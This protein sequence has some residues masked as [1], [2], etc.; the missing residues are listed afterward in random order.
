MLRPRGASQLAT[1]A[2][3]PC[4][5]LVALVAALA[6]QNFS[7]LEEWLR[8][9]PVLQPRQPIAIREQPFGVVAL[10]ERRMPEHKRNGVNCQGR[11]TYSFHRQLASKD[12]SDL[13]LSKPSHLP[14]VAAQRT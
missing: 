14:K 12:E 11:N 7:L 4:V 10:P 9:L 8:C 13:S 5:Q 3:D 2:T 1:H 6:E